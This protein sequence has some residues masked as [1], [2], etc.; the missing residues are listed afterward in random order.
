MK[1]WRLS[2]ITTLTFIAVSLSTSCTDDSCTKVKCRN[3]GT[4]VDGFCKCPTGYEGNECISKASNRYVG[5]YDGTVTIDGNPPVIDSAYIN[6]NPVPGDSAAAKTISFFLGT[7]STD[8]LVLT[9]GSDGKVAYS[10]DKFG[11]RNIVLYEENDHIYFNSVEKPDGKE[12]T[13]K[14]TGVLRR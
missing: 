2:L 8:I 13:I 3:G 10:D 7:R 6:P 11:G 12:R 5:V 1:F 14:F 9:I 4:C